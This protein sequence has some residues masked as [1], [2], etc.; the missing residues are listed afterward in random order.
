MLVGIPALANEVIILD[1]EMQLTACFILFC[2]TMYTQVGPMISKSLDNVRDEVQSELKTLDRTVQ[3]QIRTSMEANQMALSLGED[4]KQ[5]YSLSDNLAVAQAEV[6]N[7]TEEHKYREAIV[8]KL[9]SL[10][11]LEEAASSAIRNRMISSVKTE[12]VNTFTNDKKAKEDALNQAIAVLSGGVNAKLGKDIVGDAF[13]SSLSNYRNTYSK[14]PA[15]S[16]P[17]LVQLEKDMAAVATAPVVD[18][19]GGNVYLTHPTCNN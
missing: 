12:V 2:S 1:A 14:Q 8:K 7:H 17:I 4:F 15:G 6:L 3:N 19:K 11:A 5:L 18:G 9:D 10:Y 13:K 16:D